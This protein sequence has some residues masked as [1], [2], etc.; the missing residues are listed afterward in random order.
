MSWGRLG[1]TDWT[2]VSRVCH[3]DGRDAL[4]TFF[5]VDETVTLKKSSIASCTRNTVADFSA[6]A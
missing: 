4:V 3:D 5:R 1:S 2:S 6:S